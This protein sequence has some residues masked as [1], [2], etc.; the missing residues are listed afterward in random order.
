M[1]NQKNQPAAPSTNARD[2]L[3]EFICSLSEQEFTVALFL[4]EDDTNGAK[5][6][7]L[8]KEYY[9]EKQNNIV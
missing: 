4:R 6:Q 9:E 3:V 8:L 2:T 1:S 5:L 7:T